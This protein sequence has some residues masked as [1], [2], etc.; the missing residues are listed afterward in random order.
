LI[1]DC[2]LHACKIQGIALNYL[3]V[4]MLDVEL[5]AIADKR[6]DKVPLCQC[7]LDKLTANTPGCSKNH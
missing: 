4:S 5:G 1:L 6:C 3:Q 2:F 7:L